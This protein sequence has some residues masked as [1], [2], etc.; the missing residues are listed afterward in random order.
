MLKPADRLR[1]QP[2]RGWHQQ[3]PDQHRHAGAGQ[4]QPEI[5][6]Q[7]IASARGQPQFDPLGQ[8][9]AK[10]TVRHPA[11]QHQQIEQSKAHR[12]PTGAD[13]RDPRGIGQGADQIDHRRQQANQQQL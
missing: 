10:E 4:H 12:N 2:L 7:R 5:T 3:D 9:R 6:D 13:T 11:D 1:K 8:K